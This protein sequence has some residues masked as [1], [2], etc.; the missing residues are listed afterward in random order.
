MNVRG[1][2][3]PELLVVLAVFGV[4][5]A[6]SVGF[7]SNSVPKSQLTVEADVVV[8]KIR[9]AQ[10]RTISRDEDGVWGAHLTSSTVTLFLGTS[11]GSRDPDYDEVKTFKSGITATGLTDVIFQYRTGETTDIGTITLTQAST[12]ETK[13]ITINEHGRAEK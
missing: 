8:E 2:T 12:N 7:A 4:T 9:K 13:V 5:I 1:F 3:L 11:Y 10:A 6:M